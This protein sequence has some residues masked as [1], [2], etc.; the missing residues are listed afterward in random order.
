MTGNQNEKGRMP[1]PAQS[2]KDTGSAQPGTR[3]DKPQSRTSRNGNKDQ[4]NDS[5]NRVERGGQQGGNIRQ[6]SSK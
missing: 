4:M 6:G 3:K 1:G 5:P 2:D